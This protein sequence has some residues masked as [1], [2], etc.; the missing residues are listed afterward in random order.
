MLS[1]EKWRYPVT[2]FG[3][4]WSRPP[5]DSPRTQTNCCIGAVRTFERNARFAVDRVRAFLGDGSLRALVLQTDIELAPVEIAPRVALRIRNPRH[6]FRNLIGG[7]VRHGQPAENFR[8][9]GRMRNVNAR[10]GLGHR[11]VVLTRT[12]NSARRVV[13]NLR[14]RLYIYSATTADF[15]EKYGAVR[16]NFAPKDA[17][18]NLIYANIL[19]TGTIIAGVTRRAIL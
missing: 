2:S 12:R 18:P 4:T 16:R 19:P 3:I 10:Y 8:P 17:S 15:L 1:L 9:F 13:L 11:R 7:L 14:R 6:S 5:A